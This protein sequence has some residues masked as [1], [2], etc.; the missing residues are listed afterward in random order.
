MSSAGSA[1][2]SKGCGGRT[3]FRSFGE[4]AEHI[5]HPVLGQLAFEYSA[6]AVG[7]RPDLSLVVCNPAM[8]D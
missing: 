5:R 2:R 8:T 6:F 1:P 7:G 3:T 4:V